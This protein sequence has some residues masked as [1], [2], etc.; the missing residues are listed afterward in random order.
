MKKDAMAEKN[1]ID[2][3][4][5]SLPK[6]GGAF[7]GMGDDLSVELFTGEGKLNV[8]IYTSPCRDSHPKLTLQY[9]SSA[10][11]GVFGMGFALNLPV[12]NRRTSKKIPTFDDEL[13]TFLLSGKG[14]LTPAE[15]RAEKNGYTVTEY[16]L[17]KEEG[18]EKIEFWTKNRESY[19]R[20]VERDNRV[21]LFGVET[22]ASIADPDESHK[23]FS[24]LI[25]EAV[26]NKGNK[27][28]YCYDDNHRIS[29]IYY[30]NYFDDNSEEKWAFAL[31]FVYTP[32][33][34]D[35]FR[36]YNSGFLIETTSLC[37]K[38]LM[39]HQM[40]SKQIVVRETA[41]QYEEQ[42]GVSLLTKVSVS[43]RRENPDGTTAC[44]QTPDLCLS[45]TPFSP[46]QGAYRRLEIE[47]HLP[48][49]IRKNGFALVDLYGEGIA[50]LLYSGKAS[51]LY[52]RPLGNCRYEA[53]R[54]LEKFPI[55]RNL[56][57]SNYTLTSLEGNG[58]RDLVVRSSSVNGF[59]EM[60]HDGQWSS[61][62]PFEQETNEQFS[63]YREVAD[64]QGDRLGHLLVSEADALHYY[65]SLKKKGVGGP[66]LQ[67]LPSEF[68]HATQNSPVET[69][70]FLDLFGDGLQHRVRIRNGCVECFPNLGYGRFG[71]KITLQNAPFFPDGL[72]TS[73]LFFADL[74]GSGTAD[75]IYAY[76]DRVEVYRNQ[77]GRS[78]SP[79]FS[80]P[81]PEPY[82]AGDSFAFA[83]VT[84]TGTNCMVFSKMGRESTHYCYDFT[85]G[86]KPYMLCEIDRNTGH[87]TKIAFE[88][89]VIQYLEDRENGRP[90]NIIP[91]FPIQLI[92]QKIEI[93]E[94]SLNTLTTNYRYRDGLYDYEENE[95]KGFGEIKQSVTQKNDYFAKNMQAIQ[96]IKWFYTGISYGESYS[97]ADPD[98]GALQE[99]V[100]EV[101]VLPAAQ[102][103]LWGSLLREET[104]VD[105]G[106]APVAVEQVSY[107]VIE[108]L[109]PQNGKPGSYYIRPTE[110]MHCRY[111]DD[112]TDPAVEHEFNL[113]A[114][115]YGNLLHSCMV[116]Y[117]RRSQPDNLS[118]ELFDEQTTLRVTETINQWANQANGERL[119]G[120]P[121]QSRTYEVNG[122]FCEGYFSAS[123]LSEELD[124]AHAAPIPFGIEFTPPCKQVRLMQWTRSFYWNEAGDDV[125]AL[126]GTASRALLHH[127]EDAAF[128]KG[129]AAISG[130]FDEKMLEENGYR[131]CDGCWWAPGAVTHYCG[132]N[133]YFLPRME[134]YS[135]TNIQTSLRYD[136][137]CLLPVQLVRRVDAEVQTSTTGSID[138]MALG[139]C[140]ITDENDNITQA[141]YDPLGQLMVKTGYGTTC[142]QRE[143]DGD[144]G[145]Y[146]P[147]E[148][149][150]AQ[151]IA[152]PERYLQGM[153]TYFFYDLLAY[154][155]K[156]QPVSSLT[157]VNTDGGKEPAQAAVTCWDGFGRA[158]EEVLQTGEQQW[159]VSNRTVFDGRDNK[160]LVYPPYFIEDV[161]NSPTA[162]PILPIQ[163]SYDWQNR[164]IRKETPDGGGEVPF[165]YLC[166]ETRYHTWEQ[167]KYDE[168]S[169]LETS[170]FYQA[171]CKSYPEAP[172]VEQADRMNALQKALAFKGRV[173]VTILDNRENPI[174]EWLEEEKE[175]YVRY[176]F[177]SKG[178]VTQAADARLRK[179]GAYNLSRVF[180][181]RGKELRTKSCDAGETLRLENVQG[182][183]AHSINGNGIHK[184]VTYDGLL[185][186]TLT[187]IAGKG[188]VERVEYGDQTEH[189]KNHNLSG[190]I[191]RHWDQ[192]GME[193]FASY[194]FRG[195]VREKSRFLCQ[196]YDGT[197]DWSKENELEP[198]EYRDQ[199]AYDT[200]GHVTHRTTPDQSCCD[201][202]YDR[203]GLL[204]SVTCDGEEGPQEI[205]AS[206]S[207]NAAGK[208]TQARYGN[209]VV[210]TYRYNEE[211]GLL[212][213]ICSVKPTGEPI[214]SLYYS[215]DPVGN[216]S[217]I[218]DLLSGTV[219]GHQQAVLPL[220]D[221]SYDPFYRLRYATGRELAGATGDFSALASY[222]QGF[223]YDDGG[224]LTRVQHA[225]TAQSYT[226]NLGMAEESNRMIEAG[227]AR[228]YDGCG[229]MTTLPNL[230]YMEW[231]YDNRL[232]RATLIERH[233][234]HNDEEYYT[235]AAGG[236]RVRKVTKRM[237]AGGLTE[238]TDKIYLGDYCVKRVVTDALDLYRTSLRVNS[239][240]SPHATVYHF[241][242]DRK[243]R[244]AKLQGERRVCYQLEN[245]LN[246]VG[247]ELNENAE[248]IRFEEYYPFGG[249]ALIW[250]NKCQVDKKEY[251]YCNKE[252][253]GATGLYYY[254]ARYYAAAYGRMISA[255]GTEYIQFDD[256]QSLN[257]F[258]YC[259][260]NPVRYTDPTGRCPPEEDGIA[261]RPFAQLLPSYLISELGLSPTELAPPA[262]VRQLII[263]PFRPPRRLPP[264]LP[265]PQRLPPPPPL[266]TTWAGIAAV[267][268]S[269]LA[270]VKEA[271][272][273]LDPNAVVGYRGSL[274]TGTKFSSGLPFDPK[275]FDVDAFIISDK[276][277][278]GFLPFSPFHNGRDIKGLTGISDF[279][280][281]EFKKFSGYRTEKYKPFTFR[282]FSGADF[283]YTTYKDPVKHFI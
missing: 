218:R 95:F 144:I 280:E 88:S 18:F 52:C 170:E 99:A 168:N 5:I 80:I 46:K 137:Y 123:V 60:E 249:T 169:L 74:D 43:G 164:N 202:R 94:L 248:V 40:G 227:G 189:S 208:R 14:E 243:R 181:M 29:K 267:V 24:W 219:F 96:T 160:L 217:R 277:D 130:A 69:V 265:T 104:Y 228:E 20:I 2:V 271:I 279:L 23:V 273:S 103:S 274:A 108:L 242:E 105:E 89:S 162:P 183:T 22:C 226:L 281:G 196:Q 97:R 21:T 12:V 1:L 67:E 203:R 82:A 87:R 37:E 28:R 48:I 193:Q 116:Q 19:W 78:F 59:Y 180:D 237:V 50:G 239:G 272:L 216:V 71:G 142:G 33:R 93:D 173:N 124:E 143:G 276:L 229:N 121:V 13:D 153:T 199:F 11:N 152:Q 114:D 258:A 182:M 211:T 7:K 198:Q 106:S 167:Q 73:R 225:G 126:G 261:P 251:R 107:K 166:A 42:S 115:E 176:W 201:Y 61:F 254:E 263:P 223:T 175:R 141:L 230:R 177:D 212:Q 38:I 256:W 111:E 65:P 133:Q 90:W 209:G 58:K 145:E 63:P 127:R 85:G 31:E 184:S 128:P 26:D 244:E 204:K 68:P 257:L 178:N 138:Y 102:K 76:P 118:A 207:Y 30:G 81:L 158:L 72:D 224:N 47:N 155:R 135:G 17:R 161:R 148:A 70:R 259:K 157:L 163:N 270:G 253:D 222:R 195:L 236:A 119:L 241:L 185:R 91:P 92:A 238:T 117:P 66:V 269:K 247:V 159:V 188:T 56:S 275:D 187:Y 86:K 131:L 150:F 215:Y 165:G 240:E 39:V 35:A 246:S 210:T 83:D 214:Q 139:Y 190:Q 234:Q 278:E 134:E 51:S 213:G 57:H 34:A 197:V 122:L 200:A 151:V 120:V 64:L 194:T 129:F 49:S 205:V 112:P 77:S 172:T 136:P 262:P 6:G 132:K 147:Q 264:L 36:R 260:N 27:T 53:P 15:T 140:Q 62:Q 245:H 98:V 156:K 231:D 16:R 221:Y 100:F 25:Q 252:L 79:G 235:Y 45:Y 174:A 149:S 113:D 125:L 255:D 10:G 101:S 283:D 233:G 54:P 192:A 179:V 232:V 32:T 171:F 3:D 146:L 220:W 250:S 268:D 75:F 110:T 41:F 282:I 154:Q 84:G 266:P 206:L 4:S 186:P 55:H 109:P 8:P 191:Y 44:V 9:T